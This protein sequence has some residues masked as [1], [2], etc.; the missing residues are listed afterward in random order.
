MFLI[1]KNLIITI[2]ISVSP[3]TLFLLK[4]HYHHQTQQQKLKLKEKIGKETWTFFFLLFMSIQKFTFLVTGDLMSQRNNVRSMASLNWS[5]VIFTAGHSHCIKPLRLKSRS[6]T[7]VGGRNS[8]LKYA[9]K[10]YSHF[11]FY[12]VFQK[13]FS[14][15][16]ISNYLIITK[17]TASA[18]YICSMSLYFLP[19]GNRESF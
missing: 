4:T 3:K 5:F 9:S 8:A 17:M 6:Q 15:G 19:L 13:C 2:N 1:F 7:H 14:F 10:S 16:D 11:S 18:L 12:M